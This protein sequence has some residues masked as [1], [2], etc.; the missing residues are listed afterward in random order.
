HQMADVGKVLDRG[1]GVAVA[2]EHHRLALILVEEDFV[3]ERA[4]VP[5]PYDLHGLFRQAPPFL[6]LAGM[7]LDPCDSFDLVHRCSAVRL[8]GSNLGGYAT[9]SS[10]RSTTSGHISPSSDARLELTTGRPSI[11]RSQSTA[12]TS[13]ARMR[14]R[15]R[16]IRAPAGSSFAPQLRCSS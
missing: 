5:G 14:R 7:K 16:T 13:F 10:R 9:F 6:D 1:V 3:L 12:R 15:N 8:V 11:E 4:A 2:L